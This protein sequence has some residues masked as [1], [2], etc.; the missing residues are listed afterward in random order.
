[1]E[2][3]ESFSLDHT[4]VSAPYIRRCMQQQG[5]KGDTIE[6]YD[7][8]FFTPNKEFL[9]T[10]AMH[11]VEHLLAVE[12]RKVLDNVIDISPMGC[13]TGYYL[14]VWNHH[15]VEQITQSVTKALQACM[16][17]KEIPAANPKQCGN[18]KDLSIDSAKEVISHILE[19][20]FNIYE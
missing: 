5:E 3:V 1:M 13:R 8:R 6:K 4:K 19:K 18:Y 17:Y 20:G 12:L 7:V 16:D 2:D 11:S 10:T 14:A 9:T 15:S